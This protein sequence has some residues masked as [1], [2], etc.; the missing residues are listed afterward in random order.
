MSQSG[1]KRDNSQYRVRLPKSVRFPIAD[2]LKHEAS[3]NT[4]SHRDKIVAV[5]VRC[6]LR[7]ASVAKMPLPA[8]QVLPHG[9]H[10]THELAVASRRAPNADDPT[11]GLVRSPSTAISGSPS[12]GRHLEPQRPSGLQI[13]ERR[14]F[15]SGSFSARPTNT[16]MRR[17]R[18]PCC[19][20]PATG[21]A[22]APP[23]SV[24]NSRLLTRSPRRRVQAMFRGTSRPDAFASWSGADGVS[25]FLC[26]D[27]PVGRLDVGGHAILAGPVRVFRHL[28][29]FLDVVE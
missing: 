24:M 5:A 8:P 18:S 23:S 29:V 16:P 2:V 17:I 7:Q 26:R 10:L 22:A 9:F 11:R 27:H 4:I 19:V 28:D 3:A 20:R 14:S 15:I 25:L 12:D 21:H 13:P 6:A 1:A